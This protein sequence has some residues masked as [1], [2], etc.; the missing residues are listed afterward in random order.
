MQHSLG[1]AVDNAILLAIGRSPL[2]VYNGRRLIERQL[3]QLEAVCL[4]EVEIFVNPSDVEDYKFIEQAYEAKLHCFPTDV[5][6]VLAE[7]LLLFE[8][9][10]RHSYISL[11]NTYYESNAFAAFEER[12]YRPASPHK[13]AL[14][15]KRY[16][17]TLSPEERLLTMKRGKGD[18]LVKG[19]YF[20][21]P[22]TWAKLVSLYREQADRWQGSPFEAFF[23]EQVA[24]LPIYAKL[25]EEHNVLE[26]EDLERE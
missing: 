9:Y 8:P 17:A 21:D 5:E 7:H 20:A 25:D 14:S 3:K 23:A 22:E 19:Q 6:G 4:Y 2:E 15:A 18:Y 12:P 11:A 24:V 16:F 13:E 26:Y 1:L 10:L